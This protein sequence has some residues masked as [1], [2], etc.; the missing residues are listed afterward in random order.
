MNVLEEI[1][2]HLL[3]ILGVR[4]DITAAL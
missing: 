1:V 3:H 4:L 2:S